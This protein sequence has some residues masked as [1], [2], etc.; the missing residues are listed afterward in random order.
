[1]ERLYG[2]TVST[3]VHFIWMNCVYGGFV[4]QLDKFYEWTNTYIYVAYTASIVIIA[5]M[6]ATS[7]RC[8]E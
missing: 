5:S 7:M 6:I 4:L 3:Y 1:M 8:R 2:W